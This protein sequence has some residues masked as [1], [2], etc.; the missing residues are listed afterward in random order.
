[1][2]EPI[3][4][5]ESYIGLVDNPYFTY[6]GDNVCKLWC[7]CTNQI[8]DNNVNIDNPLVFKTWLYTINKYVNKLSNC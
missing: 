3:K 8:K 4:E 7:I 5:G 2:L 1:M 6:P